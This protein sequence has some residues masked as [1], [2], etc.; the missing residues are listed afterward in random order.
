[1]K[2]F[3]LLL[4]RFAQP[5]RPA[6]GAWVEIMMPPVPSRYGKRSRP[7]RGAWVEIGKTAPVQ[8]LPER[9][10]PQGAR[11]LKFVT[12]AEKRTFFRVAPRKGRVG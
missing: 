9:R 12:D 8:P 10:A 2:Y 7:A 4:F 1:M 5:S 3:V 6:R 11:G